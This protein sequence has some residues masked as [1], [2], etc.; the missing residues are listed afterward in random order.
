MKKQLWHAVIYIFINISL[1][2]KLLVSNTIKNESIH[3][4]PWH[5]SHKKQKECLETRV[6]LS[7]F[8][9]SPYR[10]YIN[11]AK[12]G[13]FCEELVSEN[14]FETVLANFCWYDYRANA[15]E[16]VQ[17]IAADQKNCHKCSSCVIVSWITKTYQS[18]T[19]KKSWLLG[20]LQR[21]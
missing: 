21:S 16:A 20:H 9:F 6:V 15:S 10:E 17:K 14:H 5:H 1:I 12:N 18:I 8:S 19:V 11:T 2:I 4:N 3:L 13:G 7:I